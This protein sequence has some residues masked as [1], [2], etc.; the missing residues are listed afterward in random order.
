MKISARARCPARAAADRQPSRLD[1]QRDPGALGRPAR[2]IAEACELAPRT[3][4]SACGCRSRP[5]SCARASSC[6]R[7]A[8]SSTWSARC[9][10]DRGLARAALGRAGRRAGLRQRHVPHP[11]APCRGLPAVPRARSADGD[12]AARRGVRRDRAEGRGLG[13]ARRDAPGA[14][15]HPG[16]GLRARAAD[17]RDRLLPAERQGDDARDAACVRRS[18]STCRPAR[19]RSWRASPDRR[20]TSS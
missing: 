16:V 14:D 5:R 13:L 19:C 20:R 15:R 2:R 3:S 11:H 1:A 18:R 10:A 4:R 8:C 6:C 12:L 9:R 7:R 17:G